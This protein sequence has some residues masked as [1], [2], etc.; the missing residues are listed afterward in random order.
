MGR[1][2]QDS[3]ISSAE[4]VSSILSNTHQQLTIVKELIR[5]ETDDLPRTSQVVEQ[6]PIFTKEELISTL[7]NMK[8]GRAPVVD[9]L[10]TEPVIILA[11]LISDV[12]C[13]IFNRFLRY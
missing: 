11:D 4:I 5:T 7:T 3:Y 6:G 8:T 9:Y 10:R 2:V 12:L 13:D 1:G